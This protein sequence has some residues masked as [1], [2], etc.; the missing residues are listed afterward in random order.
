METSSL[1]EIF[2]FLFLNFARLLKVG[3]APK[4]SVSF[5]GFKSANNTDILI[6]NQ[7]RMIWSSHTCFK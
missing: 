1:L 3:L 4:Y 7:S 6:R 5:P 2:Y